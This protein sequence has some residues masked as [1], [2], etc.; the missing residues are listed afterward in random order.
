MSIENAL[1]EFPSRRFSLDNVTAPNLRRA[2]SSHFP[3]NHQ[4]YITIELHRSS[5]SKRQQF[6]T[7]LRGNG[8]GW[9]A[10]NVQT[11]NIVWDAVRK[12]SYN[13][14]HENISYIVIQYSHNCVWHRIEDGSSNS[15]LR[16]HSTALASKCANYTS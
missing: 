7:K 12:Y 14:W 3:A 1:K 11:E 9:R 2:H 5:F 10:W 15:I 13:S 16:S 4:W 6:G 8:N